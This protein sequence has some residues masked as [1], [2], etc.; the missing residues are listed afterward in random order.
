MVG[1]NIKKT[2]L[3]ISL[4]I[5]NS[6]FSQNLKLNN[7]IGG[8]YNQGNS[9]L[10]L[11]NYQSIIKNDS[12]KIDWVISPYF[13]Y[14]QTL[15]NNEWFV[16]QR[17]SYLITSFSLRCNNDISYY[18]FTDIEN[19]YQK[20]IKLRS[21]IGIGVGKII[22]N[23]DKIFLSSSIALLPEYF[24]YQHSINDNVKKTYQSSL[25]TSLRLKIETN[26][27]IKFSSVNLIQPSIYS[28]P[29]LENNLNL[30]SIN[31][32]TTKINKNI[33]VGVQLL[34]STCTISHEMNTLV[35]STDLTSS[36]IMTYQN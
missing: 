32:I 4:F 7:S 30:R 23:N 29:K 1:L 34:I 17:E 28:I 31:S 19:S 11:F 21:S 14:S 13:C 25:R 35:K 10:F 2:L 27:N 18:L 24:Q 6:V 36:F 5:I 22:L 9:G 8:N 16:K 20:H 15:N 12:S 3:I 26:G 33:S